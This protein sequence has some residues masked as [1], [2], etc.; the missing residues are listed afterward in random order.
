M[1]YNDETGQLFLVSLAEYGI[2]YIDCHSSE[3]V[4]LGPRASVS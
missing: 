2:S 1:L 4:E 3:L